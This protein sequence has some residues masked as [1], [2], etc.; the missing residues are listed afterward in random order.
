MNALSSIK[1]F[2]IATGQKDCAKTQCLIKSC[3]KLVVNLPRHMRLVRKWNHSEAKNVKSLYG[4]RK[5]YTFKKK[6]PGNAKHS[7]YHKA[8]P[9]Y[10]CRVVVFKYVTASS[11]FT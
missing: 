9:E 5:I 7:R 3:E 6:K 1:A 11:K 2:E 8:C 4:L 10:G